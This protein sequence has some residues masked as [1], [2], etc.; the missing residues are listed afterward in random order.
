MGFLNLSGCLILSDKNHKISIQRQ[1][2]IHQSNVRVCGVF[3]PVGAQ[4]HGVLCE[5]F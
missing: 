5:L 4:L 2:S 3:Q 1:F